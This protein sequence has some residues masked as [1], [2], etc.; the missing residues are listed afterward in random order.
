MTNLEMKRYEQ[1]KDIYHKD[2]QLLEFLDL[3]IRAKQN[4][5]QIFIEE[6]KDISLYSA[7]ISGLAEL[8]TIISLEKE[9]GKN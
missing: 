9:E 8:R 4:M 6:G 2:S 7:S 5:L 1:L 3:H